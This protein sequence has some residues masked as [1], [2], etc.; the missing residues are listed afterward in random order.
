LETSL[1][2]QKKQAIKTLKYLIAKT[3]HFKT[4]TT[5]NTYTQQNIDLLK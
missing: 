5:L 1:P 4:R 2:I 3:A